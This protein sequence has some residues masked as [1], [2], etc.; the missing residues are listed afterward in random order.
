M[1]F[2]N[3]ELWNP[4]LNSTQWGVDEIKSKSFKNQS[5]YE[6]N[7]TNLKQITHKIKSGMEEREKRWENY[8]DRWMGWFDI[9]GGD[10]FYEGG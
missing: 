4:N 1:L 10:V 7:Q 8:M 9:G 3:W 2:R 5:I 6:I